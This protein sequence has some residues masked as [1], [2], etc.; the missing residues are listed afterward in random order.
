MQQK[1][2]KKT[3]HI[4][5]TMADAK[6]SAQIGRKYITFSMRVPKDLLRKRLEE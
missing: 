6:I 3:K 1:R 4:K 5:L 2:K